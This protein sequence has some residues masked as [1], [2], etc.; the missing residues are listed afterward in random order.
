[1]VSPPNYRLMEE[2]V[3]LAAL[4]NNLQATTKARSARKLV[5]T[6]L[7]QAWFSRNLHLWLSCSYFAHRLSPWLEM[8]PLSSS[9]VMRPLQTMEVAKALPSQAPLRSSAWSWRPSR[10]SHSIQVSKTSQWPQLS[11]IR[12][13]A[14]PSS[15]YWSLSVSYTSLRL[16]WPITSGPYILSAGRHHHQHQA[17]IHNRTNSVKIPCRMLPKS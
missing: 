15:V 14:K 6:P 11:R 4:P 8:L 16:L 10:S 13:E 3:P 7:H 5:A 1:M 12:L 2:A 17:V 9:S